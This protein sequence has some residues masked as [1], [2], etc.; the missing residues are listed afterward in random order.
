MV[1]NCILGQ[2]LSI[3]YFMSTA[4]IHFSHHIKNY[5]EIHIWNTQKYTNYTCIVTILMSNISVFEGW[6]AMFTVKGLCFAL[7]ITHVCTCVIY[8]KNGLFLVMVQDNLQNI[9]QI[10]ITLHLHIA[11]LDIMDLL[12]IPAKVRIRKPSQVLLCKYI[13]CI[14]F[15]IAEWVW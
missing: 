4:C 6:E 12:H 3:L 8:I 13:W 11:V 1:F 14:I 2:H 7:Y 5:Y 9:H 15:Y 10:L